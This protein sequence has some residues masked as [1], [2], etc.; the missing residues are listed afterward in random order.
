MSKYGEAELERPVSDS[1]TFEQMFLEQS[2]RELNEALKKAS[3]LLDKIKS[4]DPDFDP[5]YKI[6]SGLARASSALPDE[7]IDFR[8]LTVKG[9]KLDTE[10]ASSKENANYVCEDN[11]D[12]FFHVFKPEFVALDKYSVDLSKNIFVVQYYESCQLKKTSLVDGFD[13]YADIAGLGVKQN[14]EDISSY[15]YWW[16]LDKNGK[17]G[18]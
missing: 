2:K 18:K 5:G 12:N 15:I 9:Y 10:I 14:Q 6:E 4:R 7:A 13:F 1:K 17:Y 3:E 11:E 16:C 8:N